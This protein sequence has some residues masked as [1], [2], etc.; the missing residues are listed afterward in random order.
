MRKFSVLHSTQLKRTHFQQEG[1]FISSH[2]LCPFCIRSLP[3]IGTMVYIQQRTIGH[4]GSAVFTYCCVSYCTCVLCKCASLTYLI[5]FILLRTFDSFC[6]AH[7]HCIP[8]IYFRL[9]QKRFY[10]KLRKTQNNRNPTYFI[11][12]SFF[13]TISLELSVST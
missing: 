5:Y 3:I 4:C 10:V 12:V 1:A 11:I 8:F 9:E 13:R 6:A 7:M 2:K